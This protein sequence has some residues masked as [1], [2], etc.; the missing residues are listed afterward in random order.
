MRLINSSLEHVYSSNLVPNHG[1]IRF[2]RFV[3]R[4]T[5]HLCNA[6]YFSTIFNTP[7]KRFTKILHFEF[8]DLNRA[9]YVQSLHLHKHCFI[10]MLEISN[11]QEAKTL[12][13]VSDILSVRQN[14]FYL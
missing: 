6:I 1:L 10:K 7:Y 14:R 12:R 9:R 4:F 8:L 13:W 3:L 2:I 5:V 11:I